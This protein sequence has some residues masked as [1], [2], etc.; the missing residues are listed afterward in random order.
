M[1][2]VTSSNSFSLCLS[3]V[4]ISEDFSRDIPA[5]S[6]TCIQILPS[7]SSGMKSLPTYTD[8][9]MTAASTAAMGA[10]SFRGAPMMAAVAALYLTVKASIHL[11][12]YTFC[13]LR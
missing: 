8:S 1:T 9:P 6:C 4:A 5:G 3:S 7:S 13:G 2:Y 12:R 10:I 11:L